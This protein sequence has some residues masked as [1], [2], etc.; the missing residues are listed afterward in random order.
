MSSSAKDSVSPRQEEQRSED[1]AAERD[2]QCA[3]P[4]ELPASRTRERARCWAQY[5]PR[6]RGR[7]TEPG[8]SSARSS[9]VRIVGAQN[10]WSATSAP[11][12]AYTRN[13]RPSSPHDVMARMSCGSPPRTTSETSANTCLMSSDSAIVCRRRSRLSRRSR[14]SV[15]TLRRLS[16]C[17]A[18][19]SRSATLS[20]RVWCASVKAFSASDVSHTAP[21]TRVPCTVEIMRDRASASVGAAEAA[22]SAMRCPVTSISPDARTT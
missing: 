9:P 14:R 10:D 8:W 7:R 16:W 19:D 4:T 20:I 1:A 2:R 6:R 18:S 15:S 21:C 3:A 22:A 13:E 12:S 17:R 5:P 11:A